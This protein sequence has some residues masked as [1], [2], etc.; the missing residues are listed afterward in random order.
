MGSVGEFPW[1]HILASF[2]CWQVVQI[3]VI[4]MGVQWHLI[5]IWPALGPDAAPW[6]LGSKLLSGNRLSVFCLFWPGRHHTLRCM[7]NTGVCRPSCRRT[8]HPYLYCL[9]YQPCCLQSYMRISIAGREEKD[10]WS[11]ENR[12][13]KIPWVLEIAIFNLKSGPLIKIHA[14]AT[15]VCLSSIGNH[16]EKLS[17]AWWDTCSILDPA[18]W[19]R[20]LENRKDKKKLDK[21]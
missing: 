19:E 20:R 7:G 11:Q 1:F 15:L 14:S 18:P 9:N 8:E 21:P 2:W 4:L 17:F 16:G 10:D 13:P 12:W 6:L 5:L 3:L